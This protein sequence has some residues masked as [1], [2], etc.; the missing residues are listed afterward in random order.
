MTLTKRKL[1]E[2]IFENRKINPKKYSK[3]INDFNIHLNHQKKKLII[4]PNKSENEMIIKDKSLNYNEYNKL[5][6]I[7]NNNTIIKNNNSE[8]FENNIEKNSINNNSFNYNSNILNKKIKSPLNDENFMRK[9]N[10]KNL[11]FINS[12]NNQSF[13]PF[14]MISPHKKSIFNHTCKQG[15]FLFPFYYYFLDVIFDNLV[16]PKRFFNLSRKYFTIYNFMC[17]VYDISSHVVLIKQF[18]ILKNILK[19][20]F[21]ENNDNF[22]SKLYNKINIS[23]SNVLESLRNEF[24]HNKSLNF[25]HISQ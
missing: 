5:N 13:E 18:N 14:N 3:K 21:Y 11:P 10:S 4:L 16:N 9:S 22:I 2:L 8:H 15:K 24:K 17:Q 12:I 6:Y 19:E 25:N 1:I 23:N 7:N 20:K